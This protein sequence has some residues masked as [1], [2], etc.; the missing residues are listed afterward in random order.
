MVGTDEWLT[1][2]SDTW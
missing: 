1:Y 2:L